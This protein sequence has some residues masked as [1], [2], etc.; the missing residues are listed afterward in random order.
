MLSLSDL[1]VERAISNIMGVSIEASSNRITTSKDLE[2]WIRL[3][4]LENDAGVTVNAKTAME[5][6]AV[7]TAVNLLSGLLA[8]LPRNVMRINGNNCEVATDHPLQTIISSHGKPNDFQNGF[9]FLEYAIRHCCLS[10]NAYFFKNSVRGELRELLP[11]PVENVAVKQDERF[12]VIYEINVNGEYKKYTRR[13]VFHIMGSSENG[14]VGENVVYKQR[15]NIA[16]AIAQEKSAALMFKNGM[17]TS[18]VLRTDNTLKDDA[19]ERLKKQIEATYSGLSNFHKPLLLEG[20]LS[21]QQMSQTAEQAQLLESRKLQRS[22]VASIWNIPSHLVGDLEKATFSNIE[23]LARQFVDYVLM[24]WIRRV[25][26]AINT[27]LLSERDRKQYQIKFNVDG[28]L[29]GDIKTRSEAYAKGLGSGGHQPWLT[30]NE[31]REL[32]DLPPIDGG[33]DIIQPNNT[34]GAQENVAN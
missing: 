20:G 21:W 25:E 12:N 1:E 5:C 33:D 18:G 15:N 28:L 7:W 32:E 17:S 27:Q 30:V 9:N 34:N 14:Y 2:E 31:V 11:I 22:I 26:E 29:R 24:Q 16:L 13:E 3:G 23:N 10:G 6:Q 8:Q 4:G 19:F